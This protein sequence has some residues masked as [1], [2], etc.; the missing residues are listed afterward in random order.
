MGARRMPA[1]LSGVWACQAILQHDKKTAP[2]NTGAAVYFY[3]CG[4]INPAAEPRFPALT[5]WPEPACLSLPVTGFA[6]L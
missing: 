3:G 5:G 6:A 4:V 2:V 1:C